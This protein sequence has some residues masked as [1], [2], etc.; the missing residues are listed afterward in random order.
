MLA[1]TVFNILFVIGIVLP[2]T[3]SGPSVQVGTKHLIQFFYDGKVPL[4][5]IISC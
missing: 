5:M 2:P 4:N 1:L 3:S